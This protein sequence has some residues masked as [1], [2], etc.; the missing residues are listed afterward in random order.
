MMR[1]TRTRD[2][3]VLTGIVSSISA[4]CMTK[5]ISDMV[6]SNRKLES[7]SKI[8][9][10]IINK[11]KLDTVTN[12][13][14]DSFISDVNTFIND[15]ELKL[16]DSFIDPFNSTDDVYEYRGAFSDIFVTVDNTNTVTLCSIKSKRDLLYCLETFCL[17][18][19]YEVSLIKDG[20]VL[21]LKES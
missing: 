6:T 9:V 13:S 19:N 2:L 3:A 8:L 17:I 20:Y 16:I 11:C 14:V 7:P 4:G 21:E 1:M 12:K 5:Y 18:Y 10:G 15:D